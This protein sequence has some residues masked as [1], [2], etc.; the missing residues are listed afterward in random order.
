MGL[1][2]N[3]NLSIALNRFNVSNR[4]LSDRSTVSAKMRQELGKNLVGSDNL[5]IAQSQ[6][7]SEDLRVPLVSRAGQG[8]P[9]HGIGENSLHEARCLSVP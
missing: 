5:T 9:V 2:L 4:A 3:H 8:D 1:L 6:T 7:R